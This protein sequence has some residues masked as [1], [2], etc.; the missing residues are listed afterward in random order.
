MNLK[1]IY[2]FPLILL[3]SLFIQTSHAEDK[4]FGAPSD[5]TPAAPLEDTSTPVNGMSKNISTPVRGMSMDA[6]LKEFGEPTTRMEPV[7]KPP[8]TRWVYDKFTVYF[9]YNLVL[10][11]VINR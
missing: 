5:N 7:G 4:L 1:K 9:E 11:S 2:V 10:H 3:G 8:I 6:V